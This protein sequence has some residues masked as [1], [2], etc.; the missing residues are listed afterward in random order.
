MLLGALFSLT[1]V[2]LLASGY[3][4]DPEGVGTGAE[5]TSTAMKALVASSEV[6]DDLERLTD[7]IIDA[8][9]PLTASDAL[10]VAVGEGF[11]GVLGGLVS[12]TLSSTMSSVLGS[13]FRSATSSFRTKQPDV[14]KT[15]MNRMKAFATTSSI[16][17]EVVASGDFFLTRAAALPLLEAT[18]L[19]SSLATVASVVLATVPYEIVKYTQRQQGLMKEE[20]VR[21]Q[22]L[23]EKRKS[24][25]QQWLNLIPRWTSPS[26]V[27]PS[28]LKPVLVD[29]ET[30]LDFVEIFADVTKW[31]GYAVLVENYGGTLA[32]SGI[33]GT[34]PYT[35]NFIFGAVANLS[36]QVYSDLLYA[37]FAFGGEEKQLA[38]TS[39]TLAEWSSLYL[40]SAITG[41][42]LFG[43]YE[44]SQIPAKVLTSALFSGGVEGCFG[45]TDYN[46][47][48]E[49]FLFNGL[50]PPGPSLEAQ[51]RAILTT[52]V[53]L[54]NRLGLDT[55]F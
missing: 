54:W 15:A 18:G 31:L 36:S 28:S 6:V 19:S 33:T 12:A 41:A 37:L 43:V 9:F 7:N 2:L 50:S 32:W 44:A 3:G 10:S 25:Q 26:S 35:E 11:A 5:A 1:I 21:L 48:V 51:A 22:Q 55:P 38:V 47:C 8:T 45:S 24:E 34:F 20:D 46:L 14:D 30:T 42:T 27:D 4:A 40:S 17:N 16:G 52:L 49:S 53:S 23:L 13:T 29:G 39:R